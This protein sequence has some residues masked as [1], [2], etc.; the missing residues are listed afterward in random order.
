MTPAYSWPVG[1]LS[2]I[3]SAAGFET[4]SISDELILV[5]GRTPLAVH[6]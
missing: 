1:D 5:I 4:M 6:A 2:R 3:L